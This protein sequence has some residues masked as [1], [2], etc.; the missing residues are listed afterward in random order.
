[1]QLDDAPEEEP[2][3]PEPETEIAAGS[4]SEIPFDDVKDPDDTI[5]TA[6]RQ[7][8]APPIS[9]EIPD[10]GAFEQDTSEAAPPVQLDRPSDPIQ[11]KT[12][13]EAIQ[14]SPVPE[15][16]DIAPFEEDTEKTKEP[17]THV[18]VKSTGEVTEKH[19]IDPEIEI[20]K[21][22]GSVESAI[23]KAEAPASPVKQTREPETTPAELAEEP[24][25][26]HDLE[27][28]A[29]DPVEPTPE[30]IVQT[31]HEPASQPPATVQPEVAIDQ[32]LATGLPE[33]ALDQPPAA[34]EL[35]T[36]E[37]EL[38]PAA[39]DQ[40]P[41]TVDQRPAAGE[42]PTDEVELTPAAFD[43]PLTTVDQ[44]PA[45][46]ELPTDKVE[47]TAEAFDQLLTTIHRQPATSL[48]QPVTRL[49]KQSSALKSL[50]H[51]LYLPRLNLWKRQ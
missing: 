2:R 42:L 28:S 32:R 44:R 24:T 35:P 5:E 10:V 19:D 6:I 4:D 8:E 34:G 21:P 27:K 33:A 20:A 50:R 7:S 43:Q 48:L 31:K 40:P 15:T 1:M 18:E 37:V 38:T 11:R 45:A 30:E 17:P 51:L 16:E 39:F 26:L 49:P 14:E 22:P 29:I 12:R 3:P 13:P 23:Q 47:L 36:D 46:G 41:T 25:K 9:E